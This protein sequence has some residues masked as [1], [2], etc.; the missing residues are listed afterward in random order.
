MLAVHEQFISSTKDLVTVLHLGS[1]ISEEALN[2]YHSLAGSAVPLNEGER[3]LLKSLAE[4]CISDSQPQRIPVRE[5]RAIVNLGRVNNE[6]IP[7]VDTPTDI[8]RLACAL[9][10]GDVTLVEKTKFKSFPRK[11]RALLMTALDSVIETSPDKLADVNQYREPWKRLAERLHPHE[12]RRLIHA[13]DVFAVARRNKR[14]RS[15]TA[16][17]EIAFADNNIMETVKLLAVAPG[18]LFRSLDRILRSLARQESATLIDTVQAVIHKVSGRVILSVREHL[19][20]RMAER[21]APGRIF[22]NSRG[23]AWVASDSR[24]AIEQGAI[25]K[26]FDIFD[27]ELL[28]RLPNVKQLIV[29]HEVSSLALPLSDK[30]KASGFAIMPRGSMSPIGDGILRFFVYWKE[31]GQRTDYDL[32][33]VLLDENYQIVNQLSWTNLRTADDIGGHSGDITSA[34]LGATEFVDIN[35]ESVNC[36]YIIPQVNIFA[37]ESF[38]EVEQCFFGFMERTPEQR[39]KPFEAATVRMKSDLRG[40]GK[41]ALPLAFIKDK[42]KWSVKWMHLYLTGRPRFNR[43][44]TNCLSTALLVRAIVQ[45]QYVSVGYLADLL[46]RKADNSSWYEGQELTEPITYIGIEIPEGIPPGSKLISLSNLPDI[47]PA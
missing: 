17:V 15:L 36:K 7:I 10:G 28:R 12:Y 20:N 6:R 5:N 21:E 4:I 47:I 27:A 46:S 41:I 43:V 29:N 25:E 44:E 16:K 1:P 2:L 18:M 3:E 9:S 35:L 42:D 11:V 45:R 30:N 40:K 23:K 37:G 32:S 26:L 13:Q 33:V 38:Q 8:L 19:Q 22:A 34:A 24:I 14:V 31:K 39:G